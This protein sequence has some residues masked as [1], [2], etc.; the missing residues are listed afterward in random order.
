MTKKIFDDGSSIEWVDKETLKYSEQG[1]SVLVWVDY[2]RESFLKFG[3]VINASSIIKW[4]VYPESS[5][6]AKELKL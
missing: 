2:Y 3:R 6:K 5:S 1:F 4:N